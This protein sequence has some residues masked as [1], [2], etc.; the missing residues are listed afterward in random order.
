M[1]NPS[2]KHALLDAYRVPGFRAR[3]RVEGADHKPP[4]VVIT[5][6]RRQKKRGAAVAGRCIAAFM[7]ADGIAPVTLVVAT[8]R[9]IW[10]LNGAVWTARGAAA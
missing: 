6:D 3:A 4:A 8:A 9:F 7:T 1:K 5:L 2:D 10:T